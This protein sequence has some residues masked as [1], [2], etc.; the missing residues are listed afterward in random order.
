MNSQNI[1][2][3]CFL[4]TVLCYKQWIRPFNNLRSMQCSLNKSKNW[5]SRPTLCICVQIIS[6]ELPELLCLTLCTLTYFLLKYINLSEALFPPSLPPIKD[7]SK[8]T[9][10]ERRKKNGETPTFFRGFFPTDRQ[11]KDENGE[12][13]KKT[14]KRKSISNK[15][16]REKGSERPPPTGYHLGEKRTKRAEKKVEQNI[17]ATLFL[18]LLYVRTYVNKIWAQKTQKSVERR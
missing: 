8:L 10:D 14:K 13:E 7:P 18:A 2:S 11:R 5:S 15:S 3:M 1:I 4:T 9:H 6:S 17:A 16:E 12:R